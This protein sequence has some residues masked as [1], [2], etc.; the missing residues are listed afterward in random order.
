MAFVLTLL[1]GRARE[2][3]VA[4]WEARA[5]CCSSFNGFCAEMS[6]LFDRSARGDEAA[7][8]LSRLTQ[9]RR[10]ITDYS[11]QFQTLVAACEWNNEAL[12]ARF[13]DGLNATIADEIAALDL[14]RDLE[15]LTNLCLRVESRVN[16]RRRPSPTSWRVRDAGA[17]APSPV[18]SAPDPDPEPMQLGRSRLSPA[19]KQ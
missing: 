19:Q 12:R 6:S 15:E 13:L 18:M 9:G 17:A 8:Q 3:G 1:T 14:P 5:P 4:V 2:W 11:I 16:G 7:S 10:S